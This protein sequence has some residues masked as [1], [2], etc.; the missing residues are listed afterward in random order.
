MMSEED[1]KIDKAK[2]IEIIIAQAKLAP[3][4]IFLPTSCICPC[5]FDFVDYSKAHTK[6]ITG[7]PK[8]NRSFCE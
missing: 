7:C 5:G 6:F 4:H 2:R 1:E 8:C 3:W